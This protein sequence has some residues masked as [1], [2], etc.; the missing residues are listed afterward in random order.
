[1][2]ICTPCAGSHFGDGGRGSIV[3]SHDEREVA[4]AHFVL[5]LYFFLLKPVQVPV[6]VRADRVV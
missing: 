1:M 3:G 6:A 5:F 4:S 2:L